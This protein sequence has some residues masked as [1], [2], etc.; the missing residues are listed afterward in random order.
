MIICFNFLTEYT[1]VATCKVG[2]RGVCTTN[3]WGGLMAQEHA[4]LDGSVHNTPALALQPIN[5]HLQA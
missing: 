4:T 1:I 2:T 3:V 5:T